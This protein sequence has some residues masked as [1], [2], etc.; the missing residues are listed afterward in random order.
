[1]RLFTPHF[2]Y[3]F[4]YMREAI[5]AMRKLWTEDVASF[6]GKWIRFP[7]AVCRPKPAAK[8]HP[9]VLIGGM[10]PNAL[11]RVG[12]YGDGWLPIGVP[13]D[14]VREAAAEITR[15][16]REKGRDP[17][18]ISITAMLGAPPGMEEPM[19]D[20]MPGRDV[21]TAYRDAGAERVV[22]SIPTLGRDQALRHLDRLA[23]ALPA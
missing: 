5:A 23:A 19:L 17:E 9:P 7:G 11:K 1:M 2:P 22:V 16:A 13:P 20:A 15:V 4:A 3:R 14:G 6:E 18:K 8:P 21:V 10:G 12:T